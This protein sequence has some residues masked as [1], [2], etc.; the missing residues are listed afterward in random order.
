LKAVERRLK[1]LVH[2][3]P[4]V[5][6]A[7]YRARYGQFGP[8]L[9]DTFFIPSWLGRYEALAIAETCYSLP[10]NAIVV[11]IG[12]FLGTSSIMLAGARK[13]RGSGRVHC[14]DPFDASGDAFSIPFY[15]A[16]AD[17]EPQ[18]LRARFEANIARAGVTDWVTVHQGTAASVAAAW[19][20]P[21]DMLFFDGD[22]S[23]A[24]AQLTY[25]LWFPFLKVGGYL[26]VHN[27]GERE[28]DPGHEGQRLLALNVVRPPQ[29]GEVRLV[30]ATT[31]G[32]K[33]F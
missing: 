18:S 27:S 20:A 10:D 9:A 19:S 21:V 15:R 17:T 33:L 2:A 23:P 6:R 8:F 30:E 14:I 25:D 29:Y 32:R 1:H 22:Q 13:R 31:F 28:Y 11:E 16:I 24:G 7:L 26:A 4:P 5:A 12:S 3:Y